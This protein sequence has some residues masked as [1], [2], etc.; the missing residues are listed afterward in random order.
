[1]KLL[2]GLGNPG[3]E[4]EQTRHNAGFMA[5]AELARRHAIGQVPRARFGG[6]TLEAPIGGEKCL[7]LQPMTYMNRSGRAVGEALR[8]YKLDPAADLVVLVD[9]LALPVGRI[10][11]REGGGAG[12]HN[13]LLDIDRALGTQ[14]YTRVRIGIG[15]KPEGWV[16]ANWVLSRFTEEERSDVGSSVRQAADATES[17]VRD[18]VVTAMNSF[19]RKAGP[20]FGNPPPESDGS[21]PEPGD[22]K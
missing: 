22:S 6:S 12:G 15:E 8:F 5:L 16:Q 9:D 21:G 2:V 14:D 11:V 19:N 4:Y 3:P 13:G 10:R 1:M 20:S 17:I 18:G 7:L